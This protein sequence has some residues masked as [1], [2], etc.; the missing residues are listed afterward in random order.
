MQNYQISIPDSDAHGLHCVLCC[1]VQVAGFKPERIACRHLALSL[2]EYGFRFM[3]G[4]INKGE[5]F[6]TLPRTVAD[7][8]SLN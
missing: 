8:E 5:K 4:T 1:Y 6:T 3:R 2:S 7:I